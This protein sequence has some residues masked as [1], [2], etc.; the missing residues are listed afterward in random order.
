MQLRHALFILLVLLVAACGSEPSSEI[1][2]LELELKENPTP[3]TGQALIKAYEDAIAESNNPEAQAELL[4]RAAEAEI[5]L[6]RFPAAAELLFR[7]LKAYPQTNQA[8]KNA[9]L[10]GSIYEDKMK[11][12]EMGQTV[13]Q[14]LVQAYPESPE[15]AQ[16]NPRIPSDAGLVTTRI[17]EMGKK[18]FGETDGKID[19]RLANNYI[20]ACEMYA[21]VLPSSDQS[22]ELLYKGA[23]IARTI[24]SF[25]RALE[26]Y[27]SLEQ[28][29]PNY[30]KVPLSMFLRAFT[31][32][33]DLK[34]FDDARGLYEG[35]LAKYPD[36]EFAE[37][38]KFLLENLGKDDSEIIQS[39]EEKNEG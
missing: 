15:I 30:E 5:S 12:A 27:E 13:Y 38:A 36:H 3:E 22:P 4:Y 10:L 18:I 25:P 2:R 21:S 7:S 14:I 32:D 33:N 8:P 1:E 20:N 29:Y 24:R 28:N 23:E 26:M 35:F 19:F 11:D 34:R 16:A 17:E 37:P 6:N 9:L 31:L 39:F